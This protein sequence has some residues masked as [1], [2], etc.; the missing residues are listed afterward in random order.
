MIIRG[1]LPTVLDHPVHDTDGTKIG[2]AKHVFLDDATGQPEWV[3]VNTGLFGTSE[4]LVPIHDARIVED[5]LEV[6]YAKDR[7]EPVI[8]DVSRLAG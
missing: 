3:S 7:A 1:Q 6:R 8:C 2:D 5:R 4:S